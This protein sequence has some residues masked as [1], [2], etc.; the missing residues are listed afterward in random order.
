MAIL[1]FLV[2]AAL[3]AVSEYPHL[4]K[5]GILSDSIKNNLEIYILYTPLK[6]INKS[7]HQFSIDIC[8]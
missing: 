5:A 7:V 4:H 3:Q 1:E 8:Q 2:G 6:W